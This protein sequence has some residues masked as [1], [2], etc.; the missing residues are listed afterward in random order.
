MKIENQRISKEKNLEDIMDTAENAKQ[1]K[2]I[3]KARKEKHADKESGRKKRRKS[4]K[5][6]KIIV[7]IQSEQMFRMAAYRSFGKNEEFGLEYCQGMSFL[8][9]IPIK[10]GI[11][12]NR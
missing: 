4:S 10:K 5:I 3:E 7:K 9:T 11:L 12:I 8:L 6:M 2:H 1:R